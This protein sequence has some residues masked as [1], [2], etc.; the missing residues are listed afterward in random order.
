MKYKGNYATLVFAMYCNSIFR[1]VLGWTSTSE[2][3]S[4]LFSI[5]QSISCRKDFMAACMKLDLAQ[6]QSQAQP[7]P[8]KKADQASAVARI[9][10]CIHAVGLQ[11][12]R[13]R[14]CCLAIE[15]PCFGR[16]VNPISTRGADY[17]HHITAGIPGFS[18]RPTAQRS[19]K[20]SYLPD[21]VFESGWLMRSLQ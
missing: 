20:K 8:F 14:G 4:H 12:C 11:A 10:R 9:H 7:V 21:Q 13:S 17:A 5:M 1:K 18:D 15:P 19:L 2:I 16:L 3:A 6:L